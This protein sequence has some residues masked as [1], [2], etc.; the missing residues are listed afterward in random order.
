LLV[1]REKRERK[2]EEKEKLSS[3]ARSIVAYPSYQLGTKRG[4][5]RRE[6]TMMHIVEFE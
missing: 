2:G 1:K 3:N 6:L 4:R 5:F